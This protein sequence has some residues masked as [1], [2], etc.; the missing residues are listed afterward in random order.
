MNEM[1]SGPGGGP[2]LQPTDLAALNRCVTAN[3]AGAFPTIGG[4]P[5]PPAKTPTSAYADK[6]FRR[7]LMRK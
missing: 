2:D 1:L 3:G 5:P 7:K 4:E 6:R